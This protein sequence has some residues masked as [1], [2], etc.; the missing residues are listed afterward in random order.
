MS[1]AASPSSAPLFPPL[2]LTP[3]QAKLVRSWRSREL[4]SPP[5]SRFA[6]PYYILHVLLFLLYF[7]TRQ[8]LLPFVNPDVKRAQWSNTDERVRL[9]TAAAR[10][11]CC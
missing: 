5:L 9:T 11:V 4:P 6:H 8:F 2:S 1:T 3:T 10:V 7:P